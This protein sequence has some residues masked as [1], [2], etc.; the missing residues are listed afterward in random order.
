MSTSQ[1]RAVTRELSSKDPGPSKKVP[2]WQ[3]KKST[4]EKWQREHEQQHSTVSWLR[5]KHDCD[6]A[7]VVSLSC[8]VGMKYKSYITSLK[9]FLKAWIS[10]S[11]NLKVSNLIDHAT[12][13]VHMVAIEW[14]RAE[15]AKVRGESP[16]IS[17]TLGHYFS[18]LDERTRAR[19][20]QKFDVCY[21]MAKE[22]NPIAKYMALL[23]L[24][25]RH[26][27][28]VGSA[29]STSISLSTRI[30]TA[31]LLQVSARPS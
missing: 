10:G 12:S 3:V 13:E 30:F 24:E 31:T 20:R 1:K 5:C 26:G 22:K 27:V 2:K 21:A 23:A 25:T 19:L 9:N 8:A 11:T 15:H 14:M 18:T 28:D 17:S 6:K 7:H 16:T 4:F 29:Y